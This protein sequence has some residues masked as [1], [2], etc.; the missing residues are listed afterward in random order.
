MD[1]FPSPEE[2]PELYNFLKN[3]EYE[4]VA[5]LLLLSATRQSNPSGLSEE[6]KTNRLSLIFGFQQLLDFPK[7]VDN[8]RS[9]K[10][11][12]K[13]NELPDTY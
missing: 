5:L 1:G 13:E 10:E 8:F 3:P 7:I 9:S 12:V 6:E 11:E 2:D 4:R